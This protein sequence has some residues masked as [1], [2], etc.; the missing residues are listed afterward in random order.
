MSVRRG[1]RY[2]FVRGLDLVYVGKQNVFYDLY[3]WK[4]AAST[5]VSRLYIFRPAV[6]CGGA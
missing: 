6:V 4:L 2:R 3:G 5:E 1:A